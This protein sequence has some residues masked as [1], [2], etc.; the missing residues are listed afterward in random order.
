MDISANIDWISSTYLTE[1]KSDCVREIH[2]LEGAEGTPVWGYNGYDTAKQYP[3]G[4]IMMWHSKTASMGVYVVY[5]AKCIARLFE[6]RGVQQDVLLDTLATN[7]RISRLDVALDVENG[8]INIAKLYKD[9]KRG[10]IST[11]AKSFGY[12]ESANINKDGKVEGCETA[13]IGSMTKRKKLLRIYDKGQQLGLKIDLKRFELE[14]HGYPAINAAKTLK[15]HEYGEMPQDI[16]GMIQGYADFTETSARKV[17]A[18][19]DKIKLTHAR[20]K[21]SNTAQWLIDVVAPTLA[22]ECFQDERL[23]AD[24]MAKFQFEFNNLRYQAG[25]ND[26]E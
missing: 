22:R 12:V 1:N 8:R 4:A 15:S 10:K 3:S 2:S 20:Y 21:K 26:K 9:A 13:Y 23:F 16:A 19:R 17:F 11:R 7:G 5:T 18:H 25:Y 6:L 24:F 14:L